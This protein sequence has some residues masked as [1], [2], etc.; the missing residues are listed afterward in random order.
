MFRPEYLQV[1]SVAADG[2]LRIWDL[3]FG[4]EVQRL[5]VPKS[6]LQCV[7][8]SP[9]GNR[10]VVGGTRGVQSWDLHGTP[11][12]DKQCEVRTNVRAVRFLPDARSAIVACDYGVLLVDTLTGAITH[13][14]EVPIAATQSLC[15]LPDSRFAAGGHDGVVRIMELPH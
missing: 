8:F 14:F 13:R 7:D 10:V 6:E 11:T 2:T 5:E 3:E 12:Q 1:A 9:D 4:D 15:L